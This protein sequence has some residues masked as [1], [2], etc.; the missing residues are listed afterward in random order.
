VIVDNSALVALIQR[1]TT[2]IWIA[3]LFTTASAADDRS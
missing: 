2:A 1:E 3:E